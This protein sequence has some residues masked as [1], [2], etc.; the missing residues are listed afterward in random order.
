MSLRHPTGAERILICG[1][2]FPVGTVGGLPLALADLASALEQLGWVVD[3]AV[4]PSSL[5]L[6]TRD[7]RAGGPAWTRRRWAWLPSLRWCPEGVRTWL[8]HLLLG[9]GIAKTQSDAFVA[10]EVRL[11]QVSYAVVIACVSRECPGVAAFATAR[12]TR[13]LLLSLNGLASELRLARWLWLPRLF[14]R[15]A[16]RGMH[17]DCYRAIGV[18]QIKHAVFASESWRGEA[19]AAGVPEAVA[20]VIPFGCAVPG[21]LDPLRAVTGRL[22]WV[23]RCSREKGLHLFLDAVAILRRTRGVTLTAICGPG[24]ENYRMFIDQ[25]ITDLRLSDIVEFRSAVPRGALQDAYR[26]HDVLLFQ[27]PF[28]EP[29]ALVLMEAFG[30]GIPVVA[31]GPGMAS[32][33]VVPDETCVCFRTARPEIVSAAIERALSDDALRRRIRVAAHTLVTREYSVEAMGRRYDRVLQQ[34]LEAEARPAPMTL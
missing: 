18:D 13:V 12:H 26:D 33:L 27:S 10:L 24:P 19:I 32:G 29:A 11:A 16:H 6:R 30:A 34:M 14:A 3:V 5:G 8:Q 17:H 2:V 15:G 9:G 20:Q 7:Q 22:L 28:K 4:T 31:P 1:P 25:R 23:G 21:R